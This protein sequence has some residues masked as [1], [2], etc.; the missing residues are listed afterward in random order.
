MA[1]SQSEIESEHGRLEAESV[2]KRETLELGVD[3][4]VTVSDTFDNLNMDGGTEE[5]MA[6]VIDHVTQAKNTGADKVETAHEDLDETTNEV[7]E[8]KDELEETA[9]EVNENIEVIKEVESNVENGDLQAEIQ[10][11]EQSAVEDFDFLEDAQKQLLEIAEQSRQLADVLWDKSEIAK[12][13]G[14]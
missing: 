5:G 8:N 10:T 4:L 11:A 6:N 9:G 1:K 13:K 7:D 2:E 3:D 14:V 12:A